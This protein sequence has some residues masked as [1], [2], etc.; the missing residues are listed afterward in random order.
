MSMAV[1]R[2]PKLLL[3]ECSVTE[4]GTRMLQQHRQQ[5]RGKAGWGEDVAAG[6]VLC[7]ALAYK[8]L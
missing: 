3:R 4:D 2:L 7:Y 1:R 5:S 8:P 6:E